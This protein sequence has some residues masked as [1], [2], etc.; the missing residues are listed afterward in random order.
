M[1]SQPDENCL[2]LSRLLL[3]LGSQASNLKLYY[4]L[5]V[6]A[7]NFSDDFSFPSNDEKFFTSEEKLERIEFFLG[8][9]CHLFTPKD[10]RELSQKLEEAHLLFRYLV[11]ETESV[12]ED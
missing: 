1:I 9:F 7:Y 12:K 4:N 5:L 10:V 11:G 8:E 3:D 2:K 6:A